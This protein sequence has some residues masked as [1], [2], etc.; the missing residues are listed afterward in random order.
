[1]ELKIYFVNLIQRQWEEKVIIYEMN[2]T[3]LDIVYKDLCIISF[4]HYDDFD[5]LNN[6]NMGRNMEKNLI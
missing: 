4:Y 3:V 5:N 6:N 1:M 2:M